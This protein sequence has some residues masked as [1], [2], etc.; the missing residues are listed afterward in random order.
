MI[1]VVHIKPNEKLLQ[2]VR[3]IS[4][5]KSK[6]KIKYKHK[7]TPS[8]FTYLSY[9]HK[10][11]PVSFLGKRK[12]HPT[13]RLQIAGPKIKEKIYVEYDGLLSQILIEFTASGFYY[14]F[15][16]S[17]SKLTNQLFEINN[18]VPTEIYNRL[19][20]KL[21]KLDSIEKQIKVIEEF[22]LDLSYNAF[23]FIDYLEKGLKLIEEQY[24][25]I[26][27][28]K[29]VETVGIG[30]RQFERKFLE[31]VGVTPKYYSKLVQLNYVITLM[32]S[33]KYDSIQNIAY[34]AEFYDLPHFAHRFKKLTGF[35]PNE[36][37][38]SEQH[39]AMK[40]FTEKF[41]YR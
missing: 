24:G 7:L 5:F 25:N 29:L 16:Q 27:V 39:I 26:A 4:V 31:V 40:Y 18:F 20:N 33:K 14:L 11:I 17:P 37:I 10:D 3:N 1:D 2:Y 28:N 41:N 36:F 6:Q 38:N 13:G 22:L 15:H 9:N 32:C 30:K 34:Q 23:P 35:T 21:C 19:E 8:A 12:V